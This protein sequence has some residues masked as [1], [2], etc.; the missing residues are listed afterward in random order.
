MVWMEGKK[1]EYL[2]QQGET[3][4]SFFLIEKGRVSVEVD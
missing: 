4:H 3:G 2:F 1:D